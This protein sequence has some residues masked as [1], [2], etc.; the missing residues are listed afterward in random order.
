MLLGSRGSTPTA[1]VGRK[2]PVSEQSAPVEELPQKTNVSYRGQQQDDG[3]E[4]QSR[5]RSDSHRSN[6]QRPQQRD[7][8]HRCGWPCEAFGR[9]FSQ[10]FFYHTAN[11]LKI[12]S[13]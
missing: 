10:L 3:H 5:H 12:K 7:Y 2:S 13:S 1:N 8:Y 11:E 9:H 4:F 6:E